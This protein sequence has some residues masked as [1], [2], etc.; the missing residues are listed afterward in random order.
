MS[1]EKMDTCIRL[2]YND[3]LIQDSA[4]DPG[5]QN[6]ADPTA[7]KICGSTNPDPRGK[8]STKK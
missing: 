3:W 8:I 7:A 2:S 4:K 1:K 5:S 6:L